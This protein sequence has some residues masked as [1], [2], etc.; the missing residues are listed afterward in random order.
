MDMA[1]P[2]IRKEPTD[3]VKLWRKRKRSAV[4]L[5]EKWFEECQVKKSYNYWRGHQYE[6]P[7]DNMGRPKAMVNKIHADVANRQPSLYF[8]RPYARI[9][10]QPELADTPGTDIDEQVQL[11][12]DTVNHL[13][14]V[15]GT[16]FDPS[17]RLAVLESEWAFGCVEIGYDAKY[18]ESPVAPRPALK[19][20]DKTKAARTIEFGQP[21][22][23]ED[24]PDPEE[25]EDE[26]ELQAIR[27]SIEREQFYVKHIPSTQVLV[28]ESN[29]PILENNDWVGYWEDIP[30]EDVKRSTAYGKAA[31]NIKPR[32]SED[33]KE[34]TSDTDDDDGPSETK[35]V[36]VYKFW[37][38]RNREKIVIAEGHPIPLLKAEF[39][40]CPLKFLRYDVDPYEFYPMPPLMHKLGPQDEYNHSR[41]YLRKVRNGTV[42]LFTFDEDAITLENMQKLEKGVFGT[43]IPRKANTPGSDVISP[44]NQ[45]SLS[46]NAL[47]TLTISD[48]EFSDVGA[49]G[50]EG[51]VPQSKTAT[52]AKIA[53]TKNQAQDNY[54]RTLV[55]AFLA[56][57]AKELLMCAIDNMALEQWVAINVA[58][59]SMYADVSTEEV[60]QRY[61]GVTAMALQQASKSVEWDLDVDI[62]SL[63][64][65]SEEEKFQKWMQGLSFI[66]NPSFAMVFAAAPELLKHTLKLMGLRSAREQEMILTG[67]GNLMQQ[68]MA[69]NAQAA[70]GGGS[71]PNPRGVS[72][73]PGG[74]APGQPSPGGP[75][76]GGPTGPGAS[77]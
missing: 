23:R 30:V 43:Y 46:E 16:Q 49:V 20:D 21:E 53:E 67:L 58:P 56:D 75:Q 57:V 64:P 24:T 54:A 33:D 1:E 18:L 48:K 44:V 45:P 39:K 11:L 4:D 74:G 47:Q 3:E 5:Y 7:F 34:Y 13:I 69:M 55:A 10:P 26:I 29:R 50:G 62:E 70:E 17:T 77:Q 15:S 12:Q 42:P 9:T 38:F 6:N 61:R 76:P 63:S 28:S 60:V 22:D 14:R 73:Q 19:E 27:E 65:V 51:K 52:Q 25:D 2:E 66:G 72:P 32:T 59:D 37:D 71:Q 35:K 31:K 68:Q 40:R 8:Y 41:E 36:R